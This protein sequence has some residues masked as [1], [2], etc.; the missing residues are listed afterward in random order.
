M[1]NHPGV[2]IFIVSWIIFM[3]TIPEIRIFNVLPDFLPGLFL[4]LSDKHKELNSA[5]EKC[6][7]EFLKELT[8]QFETLT[9]EIEHKILE[10]L[11]DQIKINHE[12]T[13]LTAF[14]WIHTFLIKYSNYL[15]NKINYN[16]LS[17]KRN[18]QIVKE[19][20]SLSTSFSNKIN[21][22]SLNN[23]NNF[24]LKINNIIFEPSNTSF[25]ENEFQEQNVPFNLFPSI[26]EVILMT[27]NNQNEVISSFVN[28]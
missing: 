8:N 20:I 28:R 7:K 6:L 23:N 2:K 16:Q 14:E 17:P 15:H 19:N 22:G 3:D 9:F 25:N 27:V 21:V 12:L 10:I 4:M 1:T 26:L 5:A 11:I 13:K 18:S 24:D